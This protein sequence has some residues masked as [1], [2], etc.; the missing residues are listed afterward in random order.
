MMMFFVLQCCA[1]NILW[2]SLLP[3]LQDAHDNE[4]SALCFSQEGNYMATGGADK[5]VKVW[6]WRPAQGVWG[7]DMKGRS[8]GKRGGMER[9]E[10]RE[11]EEGEDEGKEDEKGEGG[12]EGEGGGGG[13][14]SLV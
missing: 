7:G 5:V 1:S 13:A 10:R 4:V 14:F 8:E 3:S 9:V 2:C 6:N 12:E 11:N